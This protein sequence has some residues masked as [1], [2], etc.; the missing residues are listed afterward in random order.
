MPAR[1]GRLAPSSAQWAPMHSPRPLNALCAP[2]AAHRLWRSVFVQPGFSLILHLQH[3][4]I[5]RRASFVLAAVRFLTVVCFFFTSGRS[6]V[7]FVTSYIGL[8]VAVVVAIVFVVARSPCSGV[9][10]GTMSARI[11]L[12]GW[13][14][15]PHSLPR[16]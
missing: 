11:H 3:A 9:G 13:S 14:C 8:V 16:H 7:K 12:P 10:C 5:A 1:E 4:R 6:M 15:R 2:I